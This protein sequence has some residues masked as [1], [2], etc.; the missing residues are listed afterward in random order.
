MS[1]TILVPGPLRRYC[2]NVSKLETDAT[3]VRAALED[4]EQRLPTLHRGIRDETGAV[5]RHVN[6][7]VNAHHMRDREG[8]DT[9]LVP[10]DELIIM[11]AVSGG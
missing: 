7:F 6:I 4:L 3:S 11:P 2:G 9:P 1:V 8:L 10:G 5:R